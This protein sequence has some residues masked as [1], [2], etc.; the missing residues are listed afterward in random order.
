MRSAPALLHSLL[1]DAARRATA[2]PG[3]T[4]WCHTCSRFHPSRRSCG[5]VRVSR[6]AKS[7]ERVH[8]W[9]HKEAG[10]YG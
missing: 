3:P 4:R 10:K 2:R 5:L 1:T 7:N 6:V 8:R 9:A